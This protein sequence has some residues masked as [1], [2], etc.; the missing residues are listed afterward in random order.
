MTTLLTLDLIK[1][2]KYV[3]LGHLLN[4]KVKG[5]RDYFYLFIA[6]VQNNGVFCT[7]VMCNFMFNDKKSTKYIFS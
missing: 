5:K 7:R 6:R 3:K 1:D 4:T 2:P